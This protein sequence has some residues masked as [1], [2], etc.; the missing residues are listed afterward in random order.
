MWLFQPS[1]AGVLGVGLG[2][3]SETEES[4]GGPG[5]LPLL[6]GETPSILPSQGQEERAGRRP[7]QPPT[8][9]TAVTARS[10]TLWLPALDLC[11]E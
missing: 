3:P 6:A 7:E 11:A 10:R 5:G 8:A 4:G 9:G 1:L 2:I